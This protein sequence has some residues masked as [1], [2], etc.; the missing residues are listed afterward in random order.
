MTKF[1][2][3]SYFEAQKYLKKKENIIDYI[4]S[5][6]RNLYLKDESSKVKAPSKDYD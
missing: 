2:S 3:L 6:N 1:E 5:K 4:E